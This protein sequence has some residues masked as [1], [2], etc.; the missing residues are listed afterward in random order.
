[1]AFG[2]LI[3]ALNKFRGEYAKELNLSLSGGSSAGSGG[4]GQGYN[5]SGK[6]G[7][8]LRL[9]AQPKVKLFGQIY[10]MQ[11]TMLDYG[12]TLDVGRGAGEDVPTVNAIKKWLTYPNVLARL[13]GDDKQWTDK[14]RTTEG[15]NWIQPALDKVTP[16]IAKVVEA[17]I[18]EDIE[19]T[20]AEIK[21]IIEG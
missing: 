2:K 3:D 21:R 20:F 12:I 13:E 1:M 19:L 17:A 5:A 4:Q 8:S 16:K 18:A 10:R 15:K 14:K 9:P 7:E 6:L 11:I